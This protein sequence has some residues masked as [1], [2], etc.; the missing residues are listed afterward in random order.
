MIWGHSSERK[1]IKLSHYLDWKHISV[2][3]ITA[4]FTEASQMY[5]TVKIKQTRKNMVLEVFT[6]LE[7]LIYKLYKKE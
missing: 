2:K 4:S 3:Q 1:D 7:L 6:L 5:I